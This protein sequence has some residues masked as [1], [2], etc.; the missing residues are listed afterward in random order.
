MP[1]MKKCLL[2]LLLTLSAAPL[3]AS[4][5]DHD[6]IRAEVGSFV[7]RQTASQPGKVSYQV[8]GIDSRL[9]LPGCAELVAFL[10]PG[11][12]L[13]GKTSV[14]VR[15]TRDPGWTIFVP[16]QI[17]LTLDILVN[18]RALPAGHVLSGTDLVTQSQ[19]VNQLGSLTDPAQVEGQVLRYSIAA[20]QVLRS[21]ML[22]PPYS[23]KQ[24][25]T[26]QLLVQGGSFSIRSSGVAL[27]DASDGQPAK[28][29]NGSGSVINGVAH[30]NGVV[31]IAP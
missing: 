21:E 29:R 20:G 2:P 26:V 22:R 5:Q 12:R 15:C 11:S 27:N 1:T 24:G 9:A 17:K 4:V 7:Q 31:E 6:A 10:P 28:V 16:V 8:E 14:G 13:L 19:E 30:G 23:V 3:Q 18:A 25:Q